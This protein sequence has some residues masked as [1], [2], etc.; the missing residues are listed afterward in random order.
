MDDNAEVWL[1]ALHYRVDDQWDTIDADAYARV[2][3][4]KAVKTG[5]K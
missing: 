3:R 1:Y 5:G 4:C 2:L